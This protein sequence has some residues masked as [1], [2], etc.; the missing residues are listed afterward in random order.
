MS[1]SNALVWLA[2]HELRLSWRDW[3]ATL[4]VGHRRPMRNVAMALIIFG[5]FIH[6]L[7]Y[8]M[9]GRYAGARIGPD[10]ATLVLVSGFILLSWS[11]LL[12]QAMETVTRV[13]YSPSDLDLILTSPLTPRKIFSVRIGRIAVEVALLAML[14][15]APFID[16]LAVLGG[17]R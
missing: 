6:L 9:V 1:Q 8:S 7:S 11:L 14:M 5:G 16:V 3:I 4:T 10:L 2:S 15:A 17:A 13:F 12:S